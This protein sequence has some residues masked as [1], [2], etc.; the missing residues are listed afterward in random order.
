MSRVF[1]N[2][3]CYNRC[4]GWGLPAVRC[5]AVAGFLLCG[6]LTTYLELIMNKQFN[7]FLSSVRL[8]LIANRKAGEALEAFKPIY[9]KLGA[10]KQFE[11]RMQTAQVIATSYGCEA[12]EGVYDGKK[13]VA[14]DG[15]RKVDARN[16]M[17]Y[18]FPAQGDSRGKGNNKVD[19]VKA[20]LTRYTKL[21]AAEKRR[22]LASI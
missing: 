5:P 11:C 2:P 10:E 19:A 13:V 18:Y 6:Q 7:V 4:I 9:N 8:A 16:A 3:L 17:R 20:L 15:E 1:G 14:F 12:R 22:F 21:S